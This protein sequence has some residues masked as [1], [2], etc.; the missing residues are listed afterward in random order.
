MIPITKEAIRALPKIELHIH[1]EGTFSK[2]YVCELAEKL[3]VPLPRDKEHLFDFTCLAE[4]LE[5]LDWNC[6]LIRRGE[7]AEQLAYQF[8]EYAKEEGIIYAEVIL[9][10]THWKN[11][12]LE[13]L[14][15]SVLAGFERAAQDGLTDCRLMVSLLRTQS[16]ETAR[17]TVEWLIGNPHPRLIGLSVDGNEEAAESN[18][19]F[20]PLFAK[21]K[22]SGLHLTAHAGESSG[23]EGVWEALELLQAE[24]IDHG[25]RSVNDEKLMNYLKENHIPLNVCFTSNILCNIFTEENH[26]LKA[27]FDY[28]LVVTV[29]TD[30]PQILVDT[31]CYELEHIASLYG[32]GMEELIRLQYH[33]AEAVF[34]SEEK[35]ELLRGKIREFESNC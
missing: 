30:D 29:S 35:K 5:M 12:S 24:R 7:D 33:A 18:E 16:T 13:V 31:M 25:V 21:A 14:V 28:G 17:D 10:P 1:L 23:P 19:R 27:L 34:C 32:W 20:S 8:A 3:H 15:P 11:I 4:F 26:P 9:N 22:E 6:S 2:E